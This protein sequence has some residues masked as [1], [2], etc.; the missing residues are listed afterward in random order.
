MSLKDYQRKQMKKPEADLWIEE[1]DTLKEE[2]R[3]LLERYKWLS[4]HDDLLCC[5]YHLVYDDWEWLAEQDNHVIWGI[6]EDRQHERSDA[7]IVRARREVEE[8]KG[9]NWTTLSLSAC[10]DTAWESEEDYQDWL[11]GVQTN[12]LE[13]AGADVDP[14]GLLPARTQ[15]EV[16][17]VLLNMEETRSDDKALILQWRRVWGGWQVSDPEDGRI[18]VSVPKA[19]EWQDTTPESITAARRSWQQKGLVPADAETQQERQERQQEIRQAYREG[20]SPWEEDL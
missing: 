19:W 2:V 17:W 8:E 11:Q 18:T 4:H 20:R 7:S 12:A 9:K 1:Q 10:Y 16:L 5:Y 3:E 13:E 6:P 14:E 15:D